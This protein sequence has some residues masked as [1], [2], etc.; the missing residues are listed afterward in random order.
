LSYAQTRAA[1]APLSLSE[2]P[3]A[4]YSMCRK[5]YC[6]AGKFPDDRALFSAEQVINCLEAVEYC[7]RDAV[8]RMATFLT[9]EAARCGEIHRT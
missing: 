4:V 7:G 9:E 5:A 6:K 3:G 1:L 2:F 8:V